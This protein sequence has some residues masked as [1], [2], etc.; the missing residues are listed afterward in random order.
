MI[1]LVLVALVAGARVFIA[2]ELVVLFY[3][4]FNMLILRRDG[5]HPGFRCDLNNFDLSPTSKNKILT[6]SVIHQIMNA[7]WY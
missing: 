7:T 4:E 3:Y 6:T 2:A 5:E 1:I